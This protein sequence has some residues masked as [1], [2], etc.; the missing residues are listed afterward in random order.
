MLDH[1]LGGQVISTDKY[2]LY[3]P[4]V[5]DFEDLP[6]IFTRVVDNLSPKETFLFSFTADLA[7]GEVMIG[8]QDHLV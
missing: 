7:P 6:Q 8:A 1:D 2:V 5:D 3:I 4:E